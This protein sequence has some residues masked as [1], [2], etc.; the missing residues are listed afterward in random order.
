MILSTI[1]LV[2]FMTLFAALAVFPA[3]TT[4]SDERL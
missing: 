3:L 4:R 1:L 2:A